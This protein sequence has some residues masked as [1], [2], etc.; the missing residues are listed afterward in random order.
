[1][2]DFQK[3]SDIMKHRPIG[4]FDSGLGGLTV[5]RELIRALP[6]E[7]IIYLGDTGRVPYGSRS[8]ETI[9]QYAREDENFLLSMG[10]KYIIAACGTVSSVAAHTGSLLPV[11]FKGVVAPS[12]EAAA[13]ATRNGRIGVIGT[14]ATVA[15]GAYTRELRLL[16]DGFSVFQQACP[17]FVSL[18]EAGWVDPG[19][20]I[21]QNTTKRY[22]TPLLAQNIDTLILGCTHY[23][24]IAEAIGTVCGS[25]VRLINSGHAAATSA[26]KEL[27]DMQLLRDE[28]DGGQIQ[29]FVTDKTEGFQTVASVLFGEDITAKTVKV[30]LNT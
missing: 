30:E 25:P 11:H 12:A 9:E 6:G 1:M 24:I 23:P 3:R 18:V 2:M 28:R 5:I 7:D 17:L 4:V 10:V 13:R 26:V 8:P 27:C 20:E 15:S 16:D 19:D 14:A 29:F 22:L 21:L